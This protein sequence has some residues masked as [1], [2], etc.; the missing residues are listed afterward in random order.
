MTGVV[1]GVSV[2]RL[3]SRLAVAGALALLAPAT[4]SALPE[5]AISPAVIEMKVAPGQAV[6]SDITVSNP[7]TI[8]YH[9]SV[10][11]W[12]MWHDGRHRRY[13]P[14]GT[15]PHSL[16]RRVAAA[17]S[18]FTLAAG[19]RQSVQLTVDVPRD[20]KGG[21]YAVVF[22]EMA[23][24]E[25]AGTGHGPVLSIAGRIGASVIVDTGTAGASVKAGQVEQVV[26]DPPTASAP[27]RVTAEV[28]NSTETHLRPFATAVILRDR[29]PVGRF[30]LPSVLLLPGQRGVLEG[31]W[32]GML[33]SGEYRLLL[34]VVSSDAQAET[35]ERRFRVR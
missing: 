6:T 1:G 12:D 27:L 9:V 5:L 7:G 14:P 21:Q 16:A 23:A 31:S 11:A 10:Y 24:G 20:A 25:A 15:F 30:T 32:S 35:L 29:R 22:F 4:A 8:P 13:A 19:Q 34:T 28:F 2:R 3:T 17:P 33:R 18:A 26:V